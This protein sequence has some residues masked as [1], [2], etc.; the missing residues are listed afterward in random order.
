MSETIVAYRRPAHNLVRTILRN[1]DADV[2]ECNACYFGGGTR[3]VIELGEYRESKDIDFLCGDNAGYRALREIVSEHG[4]RGLFRRP[5]AMRR[6]AIMDM[7]GIRA[8]IDVDGEPMKFE[9][10]FE[11]RLKQLLADDVKCN[12]VSQ[13][14]RETAFAEK[15]LANTDRGNDQSTLSRD[16]IDLAYMMM[17][18]DVALARSGL[19]Q[20]EFTY[21]T[22][23]RKKLDLA[24]GR[25]QIDKAWRQKCERGLGL[26]DPKLLRAG[27]EK[28]QAAQW[29][30]SPPAAK[31]AK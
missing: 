27:L 21:G 23:V 6:E 5:M 11:A 3:S 18:W 25:L 2:L 14:S 10:V 31:G 16:V 30:K 28:L 13:L 17:H 15:F 19:M 29:R 12:G 1:L 26:D 24:V 9:I 20:A 7:Y 8:I 4:L 22:D